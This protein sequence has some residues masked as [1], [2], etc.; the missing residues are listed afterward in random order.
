M[1]ILNPEYLAEI[2]R[3][4]A[5]VSAFLG[6]FAA[7][8]LATLLFVNSPKKAAGWA[9][10]GASF[11]ASAFIVAVIALIMLVVNLNPEALSVSESSLL[12]ARVVGMLSFMAGAYSLLASIGI[13]GWLRSRKTGLATSIPAGMAALLITWAITGF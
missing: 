5:F 6:G 1:V 11:S 13:S 9:I 2:A 7:T 8:F 10:A 4:L 12:A 3:Q